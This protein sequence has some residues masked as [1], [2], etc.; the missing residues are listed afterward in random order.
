MKE[1]EDSFNII[2]GIDTDIDL[3]N[4]PYFDINVYGFTQNTTA[5]LHQS[6]KLQ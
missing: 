5:E 1:F 6:I 2:F 4:N 3:F